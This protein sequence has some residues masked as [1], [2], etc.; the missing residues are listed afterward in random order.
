MSDFKVGDVVVWNK[1]ERNMHKGRLQILNFQGTDVHVKQLDGERFDFFLG[2]DDIEYADGKIEHVK[3][4][5][6]VIDS[7]GD[8]V[9][10]LFNNG[11][12]I[13]VDD[14]DVDHCWNE[15]IIANLKPGQLSLPEVE[16]EVTELTVQEVAERLNLKE[17]KIVK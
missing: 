6:T 12:I 4:G 9:T 2:T 14:G 15:F 17:V 10:V 1:A 7:S 13:I 5:D 16:E 8:E 11:Y 3:P